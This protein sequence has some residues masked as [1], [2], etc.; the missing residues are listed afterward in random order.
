[1]NFELK[2]GGLLSIQNSKL[3]IQNFLSVEDRRQFLAFWD[4]SNGDGVDAVA[5]VFIGEAF[6]LEDVAQVCV[7]MSAENFCAPAIRIH[8]PLDTPWVLII[9]TR[10]TT[11]RMKFCFRRIER[12]IATPANERARRK[13]PVVLARERHLRALINDDSFFFGC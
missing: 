6:A 3:I 7:A 13:Q 8:M 12:I 2:K 4:E 11:A 1:L 5:R 10:P 9:K